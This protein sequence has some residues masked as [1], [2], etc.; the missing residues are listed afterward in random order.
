MKYTTTL[1]ALAST[2]LASPFPQGVTEQIEPPTSAPEG[3]KADVA[4]TFNMQIVNVSSTPA[5]V[6]V[7]AFA[8]C[9]MYADKLRVNGP[10]S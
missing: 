2:A 1:L 7:S 4:G 9:H 5:K 3:C 6:K 10:V 8:S